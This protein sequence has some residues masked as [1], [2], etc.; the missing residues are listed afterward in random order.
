MR[1]HNEDTIEDI[2]YKIRHSAAHIM[3]EAV[4]NLFPGTKIGMGPPTENGFY[5]DFDCPK[6]LSQED[7]KIIEK[8]MRKII[9]LKTK[10]SGI[11]VSRK[12]AIKRFEGQDYKIEIINGIPED[13]KISIWSHESWEDICRGG[14]V[15]S[16]KDIP[17][18]KLLDVA[19][20]Y[21]KGDEKNPML[22][23]VYGTA[24]ESKDALKE[25]LNKLELAAKRDHR[26]LGVSLDL[27]HFDQFA[28]AMPFF[29]PKGAFLLNKLIDYM[30]DKYEI[31]GYQE[32]VTPQ[33]FSSKLWD[34]SG[35]S[36]H[37]KENMFFTESENNN[38]GI[39]PMN[40]PSHYLLFRSQL[41]S[42]R[43]LPI[44]YADFG[45]LHR[46]ERSGVSHGLTRVKSF[47]QDDSHIFC[48]F[49][50][51]EEEVSSFLKFLEEVYADFGFENPTYNLSLRPKNRSGSDEI[52]DKSEK[53]MNDI[54]SSSGM[55]YSIQQGEGAFY[56]PKI[57]VTIPDA[58]DRE[59][60]LGT[61]QLDFFAAS[62][63]GLNYI[64]DDGSKEDPVVIHRAIFGSLERFLGV[65]IEHYGGQFPFWLSPD[66]FS[67]IPISEN[68]FKYSLNL[69]SKLN[70][71]KMRG[72]TDMSND[73]FNNK[74][75]K[76]QINKTP[77]MIIIGDKEIESNKFTVRLRDGSN[78]TE[79]ELQ[80]FKILS[81]CTDKINDDQDLS[82]L[83]KYG[84]I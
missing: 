23:R 83:L 28:P 81:E 54:L 4:I 79:L 68:H 32:V 19:G 80:N 69:Q 43:D 1:I 30:R 67:I 46:N 17:A 3:A 51:I 6:A 29:L 24:W 15:E 13:E 74:I 44:R 35:H 34:M 5:Y 49:N 47:S 57:D 62:K 45:R 52:W 63:F 76:A 42:Y 21:W 2:R 60:Q 58:L 75:R 41:H 50:Q 55:N 59:W 72:K 38:M 66:Q 16:T 71:L 26:K 70:E 25:Y 78:I 7:L 27:F 73:R 12:E 64:A 53:I 31:H 77:L 9:K 40:C 22:Q 65:L 8:E 20:A 36:E 84:K 10:F 39:K 37:F 33:I 14:H 18:F 82:K 11:V 48:S 56:G 61:V